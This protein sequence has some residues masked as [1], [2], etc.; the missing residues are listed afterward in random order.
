MNKKTRKYRRRELGFLL[1]RERKCQHITQEEMAQ[2]LGVTQ[3][4]IS[5]IE[6]G[7][8]RLDVMELMEYSEALNLAPTALAGKIET[9]FFSMGLLPRSLLKKPI[10][11]DMAIQLKANLQICDNNYKATISDKTVGEMFLTAKTF[12]E[13][14]KTIEAELRRL[15]IYYELEYNFLDAQSLL[16]AI[17]PNVSLAAISRASGINQ[18]QLSLY[19]NGIKEAKPYKIQLI[20]D[21]LHKIGRELMTMV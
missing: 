10:L 4:R 5:E 17:S 19:A 3:E 14:K 13:L 12:E 21:A 18:S 1:Q 15:G 6:S 20:K 9:Y 8:R 11:L 16:K 2:I 7:D